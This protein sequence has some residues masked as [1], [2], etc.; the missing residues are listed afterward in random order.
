MYLSETHKIIPI[1]TPAD[2]Q[3]SG[4]NSAG[5]NCA[6][7]HHVT[8]IMLLG[9][10]TDGNARVNLKYGTAHGTMAGDLELAAW[11]TNADI[12]AAAGDVLSNAV[13]KES[14]QEYFLIPTNNDR[15]IVIEVDCD[16]IPSGNAWIRLE[17]GNQGAG[18]LIGVVAI[19]QP[20][21]KPLATAVRT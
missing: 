18:T 7:L 9:A 20:R 21:T 19:G 2:H 5:I 15:M 12:G 8:I 4:I 11:R 6:N 10:Q 17:V 14:G 13:A 3:A 16:K 1:I